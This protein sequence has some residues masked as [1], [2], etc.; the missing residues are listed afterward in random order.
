VAS[1]PDLGDGP[2][3][4]SEPMPDR[5]LT[6]LP[7]S[8]LAGGVEV[9]RFAQSVSR[10][11]SLEHLERIFI[12]GFGPLMG[13]PMYGYDL[14]DPAT[15]RATCI[16]AANVSDTFVARY[17][18]D[19]RDV[20]TVLA[21]AFETGRATYNRAL[22]S[23]AEWEESEVYR[24]AYRLHTIRHVVE[25]PLR[26]GGEISGALHFAASDP[27]HD[28]GPDEIRMAEALGGVLGLAIESIDSRR[29]M[30]R[31]R[32]E[33]LAALA[34]TGTPVVVS[35]P[36]ATELRLNDPARRLLAD[37][38]EAEERLHRLLARPV[39]C[40]FSRRVDVELATGETATIHG[41][42]TPVPAGDGGVV[43]V[44][45]LDRTQ[46]GLSR[47][48]LA[49]LTPRER[50]VAA[51]VADGLADREIAGHLMLSH[52]TVSQYV[53]RI[54]RKLHVDSR[55]ALTRLLLTRH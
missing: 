18:R 6:P 16:A 17:E 33:A 32:D 49:P 36:R 48:A 34:L 53:K 19:A 15:G 10:A 24:R 8:A 44:L 52:H 29:E 38:V 22:M 13:V 21:Q 7:G 55:V 41:H 5:P 9:V 11:S 50:E 27:E 40:G 26:S 28:F 43:A 3:Y 45:E 35:D 14:I 46:P 4:G 1:P 12:A 31:E 42:G 39:A 30:E 51:L 47:R 20:D 2:R 54:Y 37:V 25:V 23:A